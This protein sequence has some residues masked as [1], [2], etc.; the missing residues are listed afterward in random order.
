MRVVLQVVTSASVSING[1]LYNEIK[2]GFLLLVG[3]GKQDK[4][5][6][7]KAMANKIAK[8]RVFADENGKTNLDIY[9]KKGEI[10][11]ISQFTLYGNI[12]GSNR[13]DFFDAANKETAIYLYDV[14]NNELKNA[15]IKVKTGVF[16]A[17]MKVSLTN[18]GPF[19]IFVEN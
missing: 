4:E 19:T 11:S 18:D 8:L 13:P 12:K 14:F 6:N 5:E 1:V 16:G 17:D 2:D 10:L 9:S 15:G 7:V 3:I